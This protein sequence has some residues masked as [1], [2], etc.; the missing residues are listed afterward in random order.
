MRYL[1][2]AALFVAGCAKKQAP[3]GILSKAEMVK[4]L[5]EI[6]ITEDKVQRLGVR[7]DSSAQ[8]FSVM[9]D[10]I[11]HRTGIPDSVFHRSLQYYVERPKDMEVI[12]TALVDSL[13]LREQRS[14]VGNESQ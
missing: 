14:S 13:N 4:V 1:L 8:V 5:C 6:Y 9:K 3:E 7:V 12:Y 10:K 11:S 2:I